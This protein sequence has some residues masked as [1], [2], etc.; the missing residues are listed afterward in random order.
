MPIFGISCQTKHF[1]AKS[2]ATFAS[3]F[4]IIRPYPNPFLLLIVMKI[5]AVW[6]IA[7][8][9]KSRSEEK[10][11]TENRRSHKTNNQMLGNIS[12]SVRCARCERMT[13]WENEW[14]WTNDS[15]SYTCNIYFGRIFAKMRSVEL[16][17]P[18]ARSF[19]HS[20]SFKYLYLV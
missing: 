8:K 14:G 15:L 11:N 3:N 19:L 16:N 2:R 1:R 20:F 7:A 6:W 5:L 10:R 13:E 18:K 17:D 12:N 4:R 9:E